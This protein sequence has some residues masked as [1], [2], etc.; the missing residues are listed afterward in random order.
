MSRGQIR[1][2]VLRVLKTVALDDLAERD[3]TSSPAGSS[4]AWP[5]PARW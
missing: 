5:S 2:R 4:S 3:A 1:D